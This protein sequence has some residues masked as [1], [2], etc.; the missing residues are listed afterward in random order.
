LDGGDGAAEERGAGN[1]EFVEQ[2]LVAAA[3]AIRVGPAGCVA[4]TAVDV[5]GPAVNS[6]R[7]R[8]VLNH[9]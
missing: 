2:M 6:C 9:F 5:D 1:D 4:G 3:V 7:C 8:A